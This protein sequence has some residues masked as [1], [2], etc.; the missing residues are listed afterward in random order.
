MIL[1]QIYYIQIKGTF[2]QASVWREREKK[3]IWNS[4]H[5]MKTKTFS[6]LILEGTKNVKQKSLP[7]GLRTVISISTTN[8]IYRI[9]FCFI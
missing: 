7:L 2:I 8:Y 6:I 4:H 1:N 9:Y 5:E 3:S